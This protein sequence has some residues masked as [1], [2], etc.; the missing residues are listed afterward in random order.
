MTPGRI[1]YPIVLPDDVKDFREAYKNGFDQCKL[2]Y[3]ADRDLQ[4]RMACMDGYDF[5]TANIINRVPAYTAGP[6]PDQSY[7]DQYFKG[8]KYYNVYQDMIDDRAWAYVLRDRVY[9]PEKYPGSRRDQLFAPSLPPE[10]QAE[11]DKEK[12]N[13]LTQQQQSSPSSAATVGAAHPNSNF[14]FWYFYGRHYAG[15]GNPYYSPTTSYREDGGPR[16]AYAGGGAGG[17]APGGGGASPVPN[18]YGPKA[19]AAAV[20]PA[21]PWSA[22]SRAMP[23]TARFGL[24]SNSGG[25]GGAIAR[26]GLGNYGGHAG[27]PEGSGTIARASTFSAMS[28]RTGATMGTGG[29]TS[30]ASAAFGGGARGGG[31][32]T[33]GG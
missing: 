33:S 18:T 9:N 8:K 10:A 2:N 22:Q 23:A 6:P 15:W 13:L 21:S 27:T 32:S 31:G 14:L 16:A 1:D 30:R 7:D 19:P 24:S 20:H 4:G 29:G 12:Q 3:A 5:F 11:Y 26:G 17:A 28:G 25:S